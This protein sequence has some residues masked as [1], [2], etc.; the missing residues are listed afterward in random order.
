M[1]GLVLVLKSFSSLETLILTLRIKG[2][3]SFYLKIPPVDLGEEIVVPV[4]GLW[5]GPDDL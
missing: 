3:C 2:N 1:L 5:F 4:G